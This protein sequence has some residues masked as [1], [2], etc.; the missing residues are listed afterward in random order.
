M[1]LLWLQVM[2]G[3]SHS[4]V[5]ARQD[6]EQE[7]ERLRKLPEYNPRTIWSPQTAGSDI[8]M[9]GEHP[10]VW[11]TSTTLPGGLDSEPLQWSGTTVSFLRSLKLPDLFQHLS[12]KF[13]CFVFVFHCCNVGI[14]KFL[15][16]LGATARPSATGIDSIPVPFPSVHPGYGKFAFLWLEFI[17]TFMTERFMGQMG[18][19]S[20]NYNHRDAR[21][22]WL[23]A[24]L[25]DVTFL[26]FMNLSIQGDLHPWTSPSYLLFSLVIW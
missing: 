21:M 26:F 2:M 4:L 17:I 16:V 5:I 1:V 13:F 3:Y 15:N 14:D 23:S 9:S 10:P 22:S 7:K 19:T 24:F 11:D 12:P 20:T 18:A 8:C 25:L 6:T